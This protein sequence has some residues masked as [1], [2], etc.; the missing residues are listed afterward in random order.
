[1]KILVTG[2]AGYIGSHTLVD[3]IDNGFEVVSA[4]NHYNSA[5]SVVDGIEKITQKR[6]KNYKL[7]LCDLAATKQV[8][9]DNPDIVGIIHFAAL[10]AAMPEPG[11][12]WLLGGGIAY[13]VGVVFYIADKLPL[14]IKLILVTGF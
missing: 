12:D 11:V 4:D 10:K 13:T 6:V 7:N 8:F 3:L 5:P 2:G 1:M 9:R 14:L